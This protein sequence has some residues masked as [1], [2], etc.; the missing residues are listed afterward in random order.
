MSTGTDGRK[1]TGRLAAG[2]ATVWMLAGLAGVAIHALLWLISEPAT[3][4]SDFYKAY[5]PV[6]ESLWFEGTHDTWPLGETGAGSFVN[7]PV[8]AWL[9]VPLVAFGETGAG[10]AFLVPGIVATVG[11][12]WLLRRFDRPGTLAGPLLLFLFLFNGPLVNSLR[13]GNTTH[14]ILL[15]LVAALLLWRAQRE[16]AAGLVLGFCAVMKL[17]LLLFGIYFVVRGRWRIVAGGAAM[18][19]G[20]GLLSLAIHGL[21]ANIGWYNDSVAPFLGGVIPAFNVQSIDG[22]LMRLQ[23]GVRDLQDWLPHTP[24]TLHR[25]ART[26]IVVGL[27]GGAFWLMRRASTGEAR[28]VGTQP[29]GARELLEFVLVL[30]LAILI[31][32]ISWSHYYLLL[33]L[34]WSLHFGGA[35]E[36]PDDATTRRLVWGSVI[37]SSLPV[38]ILPLQP[39]WF[40]G[41]MARTVISACLFGGV[42]MLAALTRGLWRMKRPT[43]AP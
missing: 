14:F 26:L 30:N 28:G 11:A 29:P 25:V 21:E 23:T 2:P 8:V 4:F 19:A 31:S 34:P 9:F 40:G 42:L 36:L 33:L 7:I 3:L 16:L 37:L 32:P 12:W 18:I 35:L 39:D 24:S 41:L 17:P 10:W 5:Y 13:E 20:A 15:L 38:I 6:A 43:G 1:V 22:F 27:L